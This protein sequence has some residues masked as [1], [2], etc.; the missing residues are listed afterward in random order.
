MK[1][2]LEKIIY[3]ERDDIGYI[4]INDPPANKMTSL[5]LTE[6]SWVVSNYVSV[7]KARG[8]IIHGNGRH[9]SSGVDVE[10]LRE[11]VSK[12]VCYD[13]ENNLVEFPAGHKQDRNSFGLLYKM[14][15][16]VISAI[17]GFCIGAGLELAMSSHIRICGSGST[18]GLPESTFGFIP[19]LGGTLRCVEL[20]GLGRALEIVLSGAFFSGE[21]AEQFGLVHHV[22]NKKET[23]AFCEKLM[24]F[25]LQKDCS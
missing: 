7:T 24:N 11:L 19:A 12:Q 1:I 17:N 14:G 6:L 9:Y 21:E 13:D 15:I 8:I 2:Q 16:P 18:L 22:V 20:C 23:L 4:I 10:Q 25:I 5:F 3:E